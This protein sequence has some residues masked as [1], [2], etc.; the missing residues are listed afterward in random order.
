MTQN[1]GTAVGTMTM[2]AGSGSCD[3]TDNTE[4][5]FFDPNNENVSGIVVQIE[6]NGQVSA[7]TSTTAGYTPANNSFATG[8]S[9][10]SNTA[11][12]T[13]YIEGVKLTPPSSGIRTFLIDIPNG[14]PVNGEFEYQ[15][16]IFRYDASG[17]V[18]IEAET[19]Q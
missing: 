2:T 8:T 13:K 6:G 3:F 18:Y 7:V 12:L 11:T 10:S 16:L 5:L 15:T 1:I 17:N 4:N 19:Q 9:T 14:P